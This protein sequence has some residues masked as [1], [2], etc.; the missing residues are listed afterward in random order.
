L[1]GDDDE[2]KILDDTPLRTSFSSNLIKKQ[3]YP[4]QAFADQ[5]VMGGG[6]YPIQLEED[7]MMKLDELPKDPVKMQGFIDQNASTFA[8]EKEP[9]KKS[10][11]KPKIE[12]KPS[13]IPVKTGRKKKS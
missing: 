10:R 8:E 7:P 13:S 6:Y 4:M 2:D 1:F 5:N 11:S 3:G 12:A 9:P